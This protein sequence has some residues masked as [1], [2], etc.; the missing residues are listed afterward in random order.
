MHVLRERA[1]AAC[2]RFLMSR[3]QYLIPAAILIAGVLLAVAVYTVRI[4]D[5]PLRIP[6]ADVS[7][8]R[9]VTPEDRIVGNPGAPVTVVTYSDI[10][11][12]YCKQFHEAMRKIMVD[13]GDS[14]KVA[15]VFRHFPVIEAHPNAAM[16]AEAAECVGMLGGN[17]AFWSF[18]DEVHGAAP[19]DREFDPKG[20]PSIVESLGIPAGDFESCLA[21]DSME[22]RVSDDYDNAIAVGAAGAPFTVI[23][24]KGADSIPIIGAVPYDT[25][26]QVIETALGR[27]RGE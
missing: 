1:P 13:Y 26:R 19:L 20:Y 27:V 22:K 12:G 18:I 23:L 2:Y 8:V 14:G 16:H 11:C 21:G 5:N 4:A 15:W 17:P 7:S 3:N 25:M 9:P 24:I 6:E 10:D